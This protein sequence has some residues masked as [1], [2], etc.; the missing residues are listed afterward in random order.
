MPERPA[1]SYPKAFVSYSWDDEAHK[2]WVRKLATRLRADG[3]DVT[4]DC[5]HAAPGTQLPEFM[6]RSVRENNFALIVCTPR[7][8]GKSDGRI[9][10]VGYEGD[11]MTAEVFAKRNHEKFIPLL[12]TGGW[13]DAAPS[14]LSGKHY[15]DLRGEPYREDEYLKLLN[16]L[17]G[18]N[19]VPPLG[20]IPATNEPPKER[21]L[22]AFTREGLILKTSPTVRVPWWLVAMIAALVGIASWV[23]AG[24]IK[25]E[26]PAK[27]QAISQPTAT[28]GEL[29]DSLEK[30]SN[31]RNREANGNR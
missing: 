14:W 13:D 15:V 17:H 16:T 24:G 1:P 3:V 30:R 26:Q 19:Q 2:D 23:G 29:R 25:S 6:E 9:G 20:P 22:K 27:N 10:G 21:R 4:L 11:I 18:R 7:Y 12:R 5:W 31:V 28:P 8:K